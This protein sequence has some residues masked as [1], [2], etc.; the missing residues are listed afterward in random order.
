MLLK[1]KISKGGENMQNTKGAIDHLRQHQSYPATRDELLKECSELSDFSKEDK[2]WFMKNL[3][4]G[5]YKS[6][7]E[8][9]SALGLEQSYQGMTM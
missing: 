6:A 8:V 9:I 5:T 2:E 3:P 7:D 1:K 4:E